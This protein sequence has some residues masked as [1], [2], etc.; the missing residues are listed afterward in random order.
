MPVAN[1]FFVF[2]DISNEDGGLSVPVR[3][4]ERGD[5]LEEE[6]EKGRGR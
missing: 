6:R 3:K 5:R 2:R 4:R 1:S